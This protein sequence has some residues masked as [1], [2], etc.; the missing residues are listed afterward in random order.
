[1]TEPFVTTEYGVSLLSG[2]QKGSERLGV[3]KHYPHSCWLY[4]QAMAC[5]LPPSLSSSST[6]SYCGHAPFC[7]LFP[8]QWC[9]SLHW[10]TFS[11]PKT[12]HLFYPSIPLP[13]SPHSTILA[14]SEERDKDLYSIIHTLRRGGGGG[15]LHM[16]TNAELHPG[17]KFNKKP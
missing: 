10:S 11:P 1:M 5:S 17:W 16:H 2:K 7:L 4:E 8:T 14:I 12:H 15:G 13:S 6:I 3:T 9:N